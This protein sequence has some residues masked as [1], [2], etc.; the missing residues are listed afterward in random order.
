MGKGEREAKKGNSLTEGISYTLEDGVC[1]LLLGEEEKFLILSSEKLDTLYDFFRWAGDYKEVDIILIKSLHDSVFLAGADI[2][3]LVNFSSLSARVFSEKGHRLF[4]IMEF[5]PKV[6]ISV[7]DGFALGGGF[8]FIMACDL[9]IGTERAKIGQTACRMG[10]VTGFGGTKRLPLIVG[11]KRAKELFFRAKVLDANEAY[12]L[13]VL[14]FLVSREELGSFLNRLVQLIRERMFNALYK[15][16][17]KSLLSYS[18]LIGSRVAKYIW[19]SVGGSN[20]IG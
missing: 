19:N 2:R 11:V 17:L 8:D 16:V 7:V 18:G 1:S 9:R 15:P 13:G 20:G 14:N 4:N 3:E 5:I 10:I 12:R 6:V